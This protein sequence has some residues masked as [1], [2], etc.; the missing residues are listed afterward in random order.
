[1]LTLPKPT[2]FQG[3]TSMSICKSK[4]ARIAYQKI[5]EF[6]AFGNAHS[7]SKNWNALEVSEPDLNIILRYSADI[8]KTSWAPRKYID[9]DM[10]TKIFESRMSGNR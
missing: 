6:Q 3:N 10:Q 9:V 4:I 7:H 2:E 5:D 1:M 8:S